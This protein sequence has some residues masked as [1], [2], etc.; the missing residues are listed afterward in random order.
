MYRCVHEF[1]LSRTFQ[2]VCLWTTRFHW[3]EVLQSRN[4]E[5]RPCHLIVR[6]RDKLLI[7][8][9]LSLCYTLPLNSAMPPASQAEAYASAHHPH[10]KKDNKRE[11]LG[12]LS[13]K[14]GT[15]S[16]RATIPGEL[17]PTTHEME[18]AKLH[19]TRVKN[20]PYPSMA[21]QRPVSAVQSSFMSRS[22]SQIS[23]QTEM[24][25]N[26]STKP[27]PPSHPSSPC[28]SN[29]L[30][31]TASNAA[32][33]SL[34]SPKK[35]QRNS[36]SDASL[37]T[38]STKPTTMNDSSPQIGHIAQAQLGRTLPH[39]N[40]NPSDPPAANASTF[41]LAGSTIAPSG[42]TPTLASSTLPMQPTRRPLATGTPSV[43]FAPDTGDRVAPDT[44]DR[45]S[46]MYP[47]S[48]R[49]GKPR[50]NEDAS[51]RAIRRRGSD[52]SMHSKWSWREPRG[53]GDSRGLGQETR[54]LGAET[55]PMG[56]DTRG[57]GVEVRDLG[58]VV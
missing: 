29:A 27:I 13:R 17:G 53:L 30:S 24:D 22:D 49:S 57:M 43:T 44:G 41:T 56:M 12:W 31:R 4:Y 38:K 51:V 45:G 2:L 16:R 19:Q 5:L 26:A 33:A 47:P 50:V 21:L 1:A 52:D 39:S 15:G 42:S 3:I 48:G 7:D 58:I 11:L 37:S 9:L 54:G 46:V 10:P 40:P 35:L 55:R 6:H 36:T 28:N 34:L 18:Q 20:N 32:S 23:R 8:F 25:D 14:L